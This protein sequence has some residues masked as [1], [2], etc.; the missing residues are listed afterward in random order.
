MAPKIPCT[1]PD[2]VSY[3]LSISP[4]LDRNCRTCHNPTLLTGG[5]NLEDFAELKR[6]AGTGQL[7]GVVSH[8][9]GFAQMP[10]DG[11]KLSECDIELL[12]KW[13]DAGALNN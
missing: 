8:A 12:R 11:A 5:V 13:V 10:K 1:T 6:R 3:S 2:V 9:P 7:I 4:L